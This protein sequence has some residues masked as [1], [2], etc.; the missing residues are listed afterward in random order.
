MK[1]QIIDVVSYT[2]TESLLTLSSLPNG[3]MIYAI[4]RRCHVYPFSR[5][6]IS[7]RQ[8]S[9]VDSKDCAYLWCSE[10]GWAQQRA[11]GPWKSSVMKNSRETPTR[12]FPSVLTNEIYSCLFTWFHWLSITVLLLSGVKRSQHDECSRGVRNIHRPHHGYD[13]SE[14]S[15]IYILNI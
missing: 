11:R 12:V 15:K 10:A 9:S 4:T 14:L 5:H 6:L 1:I 13:N 2:T 7:S 3:W 8:V